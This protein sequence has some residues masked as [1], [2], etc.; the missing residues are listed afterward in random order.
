MLLCGSSHTQLSSDG[1]IAEARGGVGAG[2]G[3][4]DARRASEGEVLVRKLASELR[5]GPGN[6]CGLRR[7]AGRGQHH[8]LQA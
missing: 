5:R 8:P 2:V 1:A 4:G 3:V 7:R 6:S